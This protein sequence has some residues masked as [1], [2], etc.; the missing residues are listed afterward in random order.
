MSDE[1]ITAELTTLAATLDVD[2]SVRRY[3]TMI[4]DELRRRDVR[5]ASANRTAAACLLVACRLRSEP[6]RVTVLAAQTADP[7]ERILGEMQRL[8][9]ALEITVPLDDPVRILEKSCDELGLSADVRRRAVRLARLGDDAG[10]TSGVSPHTYSAAVC[11]VACST[12]DADLS[13]ADVAAHFDVATA[14][15]RNRRDDLLEATGGHL[16]DVQF[17]DAPP[18]A[19]TLVD[20]LLAEARTADWAAHKRSL[21]V[22]AGAW[23]YAAKAYDLRT[24]AAELAALTGISESTVRTRYEQFVERV[25][26]ASAKSADD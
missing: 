18:E 15:L 23:L 17:P 13:Q 9:S 3:A 14:T 11:Y 6:L 8:S 1:S 25:P 4:A 24:D 26:A 12:T 5:I 21:G 20:D 22:L 16:F 10:V 19:A 2:D 7:K